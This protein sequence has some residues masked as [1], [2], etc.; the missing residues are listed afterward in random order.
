[1]EL[2]KTLNSTHVRQK[3]LKYVSQALSSEN[4]AEEQLFILFLNI[5]AYK[6]DIQVIF[7]HFHLLVCVA[8]SWCTRNQPTNKKQTK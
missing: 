6:N 2:R 7:V 4:D 3:K 1:M 8:I 5:F